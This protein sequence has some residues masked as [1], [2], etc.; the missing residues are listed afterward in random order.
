MRR[1]GGPRALSPG[2]DE[3]PVLHGVDSCVD[4][5]DRDRAAGGGRCEPNEAA[6]RLGGGLKERR[7]T[8]RLDAPLENQAETYQVQ[9]HGL[10]TLS[11]GSPGV[12]HG[13]G[14]DGQSVERS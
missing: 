14:I 4:V 12:L 13:I 6:F 5:F 8:R 1:P 2:P 3:L 10:N 7:R 9:R 11:R